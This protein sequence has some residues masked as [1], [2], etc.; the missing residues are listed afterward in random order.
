MFTTIQD[1]HHLAKAQSTFEQLIVDAATRSDT[2]KVGY[3]GGGSEVTAHYVPDHGFWVAFKD[4]RNRYWN[5]L[6]LGDPFDGD[7]TIIAEINPPKS[8]LNL[9]VSGVF[10]QDAKGRVYLAHRGGIGGGR[11]GIGKKAFLDWYPEKL[12]STYDGEHYSDIIIIGSLDD[13]TVVGNLAEFTRYVAA[14]KDEVVASQPGRSTAQAQKPKIK[15]P[16]ISR[17]A[18]VQRTKH[19]AR[20]YRILETLEKRNGGSRALA[21]CSGLMEWPARGVYFFMEDGEFR[22][23]S[24]NG[25]RVVRVGTHALKAGAVTTL[26]SRLSQHRGSAKTGGGNHRGSIFRLIVGTAL[27]AESGFE[28]GSWGEG[29]SAPAEVRDG[30]MEMECKVSEIIGRMPFIWIP[31]EDKPGPDSERGYIERNSISLLSNYGKSPLDL[32]SAN[33]L[34][35]HCDRERVRSSGLWNSNHVDE[36]YDPAFLDRLAKLVIKLG[37]SE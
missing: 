13:K 29:S 34:G 11:K 2:I 1:T 10:V 14:F 15:K 3:Q 6:G 19:L 4:A 32:P 21:N 16:R 30:E 22:S 5:A 33:W 31:I 24:G 7:R 27:R 12:E 18:Q 20:F 36:L 17:K 28:V 8:G 9:R 25:R 37:R 26:W 23:D 35:N